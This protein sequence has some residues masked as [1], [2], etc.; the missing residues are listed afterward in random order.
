MQKA[1]ETLGITPNEQISLDILLSE[2]FNGR[3]YGM[4]AQQIERVQAL[5][6]IVTAYNSSRP[7]PQK[8]CNSTDA[9]KV[10]YGRM[11][12]LGHE[13]VWV[14]YLNS[15]N[16][17]ISSEKVFSGTKQ[18][19]TISA[20]DILSRALSCGASAIIL[21]HN[22]PS[23]NT[24]PS[25]ADIKRTESLKA[26]CDALDVPL[27]DHIIISKGAYY[28]FSDEKQEKITL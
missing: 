21:Y 26:A 12:D 19:V 20:K 10:M 24:R 11:A 18:E 16:D 2:S 28:S 9:V 14:V 3:L 23:G 4:Q 27:L 25:L 5:R 15:G 1:L 13:E 17:V 8:I 7:V 6:D 22:H